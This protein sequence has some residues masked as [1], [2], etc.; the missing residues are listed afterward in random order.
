MSRR[1][2]SKARRR[3]P[4][5]PTGCSP[6]R[7]Y[8]AVTPHGWPSPTNSST[9][10]P[11]YPMHITTELTPPEARPLRSTTRRLTNRSVVLR[12]YTPGVRCSRESLVESGRRLELLACSLRKRPKGISAGVDEQSPLFSVLSTR[13]R[14]TSKRNGC[15]KNVRWARG[16][17]KSPRTQQPR[18]VRIHR[19][20]R[21]AGSARVG[22]RPLVTVR[23]V[24]SSTGRRSRRSRGCGR[25]PET[26]VVALATAGGA[27]R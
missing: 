3:A 2:R 27:P 4:I 9:W 25:G 11:R 21:V 6:S 13:W 26:R 15:A 1:S 16:T 23:R 8:L 10:S 22:K 24:R 19:A 14:T 5:V 17:P 12:R 7:E 20:D 18:D